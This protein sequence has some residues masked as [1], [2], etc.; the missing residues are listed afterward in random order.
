MENEFGFV[1]VVSP[2]FS[3]VR[4]CHLLMS[5][6]QHTSAFIP[7][8]QSEL[9][10]GDFPLGGVIGQIFT[11]FI[12]RHFQ[13]VHNDWQ[14]AGLNVCWVNLRKRYDV[15]AVSWKWKMKGESCWCDR[16][17]PLMTPSRCRAALRWCHLWQSE[18]KVNKRQFGSLH[19]S[20]CS[21]G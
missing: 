8:T 19:A 3:L 9:V 6:S 14:I 13:R 4:R 18:Q 12:Q 15:F 2:W 17:F 10:P 7:L 11:L 20:L 16:V 1:H 5:S 21:E